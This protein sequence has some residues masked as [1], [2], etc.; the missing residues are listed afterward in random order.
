MSLFNLF[1][2]LA[3]SDPNPRLP[4]QNYIYGPLHE[5]LHRLD[6]TTPRSR[7]LA[8]PREAKCHGHYRGT[9]SMPSTTHA[10]IIS[11]STSPGGPCFQSMSPVIHSIHN[12]LQAFPV[13]QSPWERSDLAGKTMVCTY[14]L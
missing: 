5:S 10:Y 4:S 12:A 9:S 6:K 1:F 11:S 14:G 7:L 8:N 3:E 2:S 13:N